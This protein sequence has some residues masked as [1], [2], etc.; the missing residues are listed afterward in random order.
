MDKKSTKRICLW[1][2][3]RNISTAIM[4]SFAQRSDTKVVD[5]PL[6][7]HYLNETDAF[8]YHPGAE[9]VLQSMEKNGVKVIE[10]MLGPHEK[11]VVFFKQ[12]THHLVNLDW[13]FL[14]HTLNIILTRDPE[15]MLPSYAVEVEHPT[16]RDTGY[17]KQ[18]ELLD[19]LIGIGQK[20]IVLVSERVLQNP[21]KVLRKLCESIGVPFE[22]SML[23]WEKGP[24]PEDGVW[25][26]YWYHNVHQSTGF[27]PYQ[28][29][30]QPIQ[31]HL[32]PLAEQCKPIY[33]Q[34][35]EYSL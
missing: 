29:K 24:R 27:N 5:E 19:Y 8:Q 26:K 31:N 10:L 22:E 34:L 14:E 3:P 30:K 2:G 13:S 9:E 17:Q 15:E 11:P 33:D 1:S 18:L 4:Y 25:A 28:P 6:Y 21:E 23:S 20:P 32:K 35:C 12:M 7:A 16:M